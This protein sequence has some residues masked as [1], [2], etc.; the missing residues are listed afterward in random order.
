MNKHS[1]ESHKIIKRLNE[2]A[3]LINKHNHHYHN[4]DKPKINDDEYDKLVKENLELELKYPKLKLSEST[5]NKVGSKIQNKFVKLSHLSPMHSLANGFNE[6]DL[7][8]FDERVKK[9]L[10]VSLL[11]IGIVFKSKSLLFSLIILIAS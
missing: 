4:E 7:T 8:A 11:S 2:L 5:S 10:K 6:G 9:F 1:G 3:K